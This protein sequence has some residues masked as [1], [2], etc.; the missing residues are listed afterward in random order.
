[1]KMTAITVSEV[2]GGWNSGFA[3]DATYEA[4]CPH[5]RETEQ[6][7]VHLDRSLL[8]REDGTYD[9]DYVTKAVEGAAPDYR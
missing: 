4:N 3:V 1:M 8:V 5:G 2:F 9:L 6:R 7:R